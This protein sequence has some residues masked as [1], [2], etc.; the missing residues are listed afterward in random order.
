MGWVAWKPQE[1]EVLI[2]YYKIGG[3]KLVLKHLPDLGKERTIGAVH[4]RSKILGQRNNRKKD[5]SR[6]ERVIREIYTDGKPYPCKRAVAVLRVPKGK[7]CYLALRMGLSSRGYKYKPWSEFEA[8]MVE[9]HPEFSCIVMAKKLQKAGYY[10]TAAA[11]ESFRS[12]NGISGKGEWLSTTDVGKV[13]GGFS[14]ST[15]LKWIASGLLKAKKRGYEGGKDHHL[16]SL[17][18]LKKF[19]QENPEKLRQRWAGID[20]TF[21]IS[22]LMDA[23]NKNQKKMEAA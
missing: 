1:D 8:A 16:V 4:Q 17:L 5:F 18:S 19:V 10:R 11:V 15:V 2:K 20:P 12:T 14:D 7:V 6:E 9:K 23:S 13:L 21:F 22:V 3:A